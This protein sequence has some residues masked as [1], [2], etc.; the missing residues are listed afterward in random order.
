MNL[1]VLSL[2]CRV[3]GFVIP[4]IS[5]FIRYWWIWGLMIFRCLSFLWILFFC[6]SIRPSYPKI[7]Y[8]VFSILKTYSIIVFRFDYLFRAMLISEQLCGNW[9]IISTNL[10]EFSYFCLSAVQMEFHSEVTIMAFWQ[11]FLLIY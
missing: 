4:I 3:L 10:S 8:V 2:I 7:Y 6:S 11:L 1:F 5:Y 9:N